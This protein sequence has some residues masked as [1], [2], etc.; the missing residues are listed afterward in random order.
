MVTVKI[1]D[2]GSCTG[3]RSSLGQGDGMGVGGWGGGLSS[4]NRVE[5][6]GRGWGRQNAQVLYHLQRGGVQPPQ[7]QG[8]CARTGFFHLPSTFR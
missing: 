7:Q 1:A 5:K 8:P 6:P 2:Q 4:R 3:Q